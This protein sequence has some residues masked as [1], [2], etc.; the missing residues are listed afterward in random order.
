MVLEFFEKGLFCL[1]V[2]CV[3]IHNIAYNYVLSE[4]SSDTID[5]LLCN[6]YVMIHV[7]GALDPY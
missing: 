3:D 6:H 1:K 2:I 5:V 4:R 7:R